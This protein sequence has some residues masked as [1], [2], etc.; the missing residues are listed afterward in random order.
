MVE[1]W[2]LDDMDDPC[3]KH[4]MKLWADKWS[5]KGETKGGY[6]QLV[7]KK[8]IVTSNYT[9]DELFKDS[10]DDMVAA[11]KRRFKCTVFSDHPFNGN[12]I[13][14]LDPVAR[15]LWNQCGILQDD[16]TLGTELTTGL[17]DFNDVVQGQFD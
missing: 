12:P 4:Y 17:W 9:I 5:C 11:I 1:A 15:G 6:T 8:I 14:P 2:S 10:G 3:L 13:R 7:H 16:D